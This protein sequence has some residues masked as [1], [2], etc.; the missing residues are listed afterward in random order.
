VVEG[1]AFPV[2]SAVDSAT[3]RLRV[4]PYSYDSGGNILNDGNNLL[5]Y[6]AENHL[7]GSSQSGA[8]SSYSY[9]CKGFRVVKSSTG[10]TLVYIFSGN[11]VIA[12]YADGAP[13]PNPTR[14]YVYSGSGLLAKI[15]NGSINYYH[16]DHLS[17]RF[18][19]DVN[20]NAI[21]QQGLYPFGDSWYDTGTTSKKKFT[22]YER[23]NE[24]GNDYA[25]ARS[26]IN[27]LGRFASPDLMAG[28]SDNPQSLNRY[29]YAGNDPINLTDPS[30]MFVVGI[31][32]FLSGWGNFGNNGLFGENWDEFFFLDNPLQVGVATLY[33][34]DSENFHFED[35]SSN[36]LAVNA[37]QGELSI[38]G[39]WPI[40]QYVFLNFVGK[41]GATPDGL[42]SNQ[43]VLNLLYCLFKRGG[44]GF[45]Q[46]E[47]STW[48][49]N[50]SGNFGE[51]PWP[52]SAD[53]N[54]DTWKGPTPAD[55][56][57]FAHTHP[58][59]MDP[60]P[61]TGSDKSDDL[62]ANKTGL[63]NYVVTRDA[64]WKQ[65]PNQKDPEL[66]AGPGWTNDSAASEKKGDLKCD[67]KR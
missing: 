43:Q 62:A 36:E 50:Q 46:T 25:L 8:I 30:G 45:K 67:K 48:I 41:R 15:E 14:E 57:A 1:S 21:G 19:S 38:L 35:F 4:A 20:A 53:A 9:D 6:D 58:S 16:T 29:A 56:I 66:V 26:Y 65:S 3:N 39:Q 7:T 52:W 33:H 11:K 27:R 34:S 18:T 61:S 37:Q 24:S 28:F 2:S 42:T 10:S 31:D 64:I 60:K 47:R 55:A 5:Q 32:R 22:G 40:Y 13:V 63:P 54:H 12:E 17:T 44:S 59:N 49:T 23:D 51:I